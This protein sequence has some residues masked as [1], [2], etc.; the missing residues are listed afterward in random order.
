MTGVK[1]TEFPNATLPLTGTEI[2]PVVQSG[3]TKQTTVNQATSGAA[4][5]LTNIAALQALNLATT[6]L[7]TQVQLTSNYVAGD[8][9]GVFRY[10]S[11]DTT[12]ADNGGTVI[13]DA[14]GRRWK[15]QWSGAVNASWFGF[16]TSATAATNTT[17]I[18]AALAVGPTFL[19]AGSYA[20]GESGSSGISFTLAAGCQIFAEP[21][22]TTLVA[23]AGTYKTFEITGSNTRVSGVDFTNTSKISG[24][25]HNI[26]C[27][28]SGA[29]IETYVDDC[30]VT[31]DPGGATDTGSATGIQ[32]RTYWSN[33]KF[34]A[35]RG[36]GVVYSRAFAFVYFDQHCV[37]DYVG[38]SSKNHTAVAMTMTGL[39]AGAGGYYIGVQC[40]GTAKDGSTTSS[41]KGF[42]F[43]DAAEVHL[44]N[45]RVDGFGGEG[46]FFDGCS[47]V[48][49]SNLHIGLCDGHLLRFVDCAVV[50]GS[51]FLQGRLGVGSPAA[52]ID[53]LRTEGGCYAFDINPT[54]YDVVRNGIYQTSATDTELNFFDFIV[55][56]FAGSALITSAGGLITF[57]GG[58]INTVS[59]G[60]T[61]TN[62]SAGQKH[63]VKNVTGSAGTLLRAGYITENYGTA[64]INL[65][66]SSL[67]SVAHGCSMTPT[68]ATVNVLGNFDPRILMVVSI[69][70][71]NINLV[72]WRGHNANTDADGLEKALSGDSGLSNPFNVQFYARA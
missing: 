64:Q 31:G 3:V 67:A 61:D 23:A 32:Y 45:A 59:G 52:N 34:L 55:R 26:A 2:F 11:T 20:Y 66:G 57:N 9:G 43:T 12:T 37:V 17:A 14:A 15:R 56:S 29:I 58:Q 22:K 19:P 30:L 6:S 48:Y 38:S 50:A 70:A 25:F 71:T 28:S 49:L 33:V 53:A 44:N 40:L 46:A 8:G 51:P 13:V 65:D 47:K 10:D 60:G 69:D 41:Q 7:P 18:N 16:A 24:A 72:C 5:I 54:I 39:P 27:G 68:Y 62:L 42:V 36:P 35:H 1:I 63:Y 4:R 21:R